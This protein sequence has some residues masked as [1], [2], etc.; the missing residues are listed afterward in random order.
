MEPKTIKTT[1]KGFETQVIEKYG[2]ETLSKSK[3]TEDGT[4]LSLYY[5]NNPDFVPC[6]KPKN[7]WVLADYRHACDAKKHV[8]T[9]NHKEKSGC[10]FE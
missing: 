2:F 1:A 7:E 9:Y 8:A 10:I 6:T 4:K 5:W 3:T